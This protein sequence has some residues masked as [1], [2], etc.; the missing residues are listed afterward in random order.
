MRVGLAYI[1]VHQCVPAF[2]DARRRRSGEGD[3]PMSHP[4]RDNLRAFKVLG[5]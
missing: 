2:R 4:T 1:Y 3:G 5:S